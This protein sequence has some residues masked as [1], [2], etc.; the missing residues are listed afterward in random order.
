MAAAIR[1][2]QQHSCS[3][4]H[5]VGTREQ[6]HREVERLGLRLITSSYLVGACTGRSAGSFPIS[7]VRKQ[8][9]SPGWRARSRTRARWHKSEII[10]SGRK[11]LPTRARRNKIHAP[12]DAA[13]D[14]CRSLPALSPQRGRIRARS[15][16]CSFDLSLAARVCAASREFLCA[17]SPFPSDR[18]V[19]ARRVELLSNWVARRL[20]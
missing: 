6:G 4:D 8:N 19:P 10:H 14:G 5:L 20:S 17:V 7:R 13:S 15:T 12:D 16:A 2:S 1:L 3:F 9:R 18:C 11:T